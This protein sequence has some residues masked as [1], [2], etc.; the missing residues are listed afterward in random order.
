MNDTPNKS[1]NAGLYDAKMGFVSQLGSP[2]IGLLA[3]Q[4][5]ERILDLGCGTGDLAAELARLGA[6]PTGIDFSASMVE[7]ARAKHPGLEFAVADATAYRS[8]RRY[9]G[10]FSNAVLH[11]IKPPEAAVESVRLALRPGGRFAAEFGGKGNIAAIYEVIADVLGGL[12]VD[13][14]AR[15]PWYF[16]STREY[17]T[18]LEQHGF[19]VCSAELFPRLTQLAGGEEGLR[20]WLD[21][22]TDFF[23]AG[24]DSESKAEAY[25]RIEERLRPTYFHGGEWHADYMRIRVLAVRE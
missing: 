19:R 15:N 1:W 3:P 4:P 6:H 9:D 2:V 5:G 13:A 7:Q 10:V 16:P 18:L 12:G 8:E 24:L 14:Q 17:T 23:F 21:T 22:F 11:W 25:S 20:H